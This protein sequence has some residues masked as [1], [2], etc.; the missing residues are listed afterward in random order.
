[1]SG[2]NTFTV[3]APPPPTPSY[4]DVVMSDRPG[5]YWRLGESTGS[6]AVDE[7]ANGNAGS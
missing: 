6:T 5:G 1:M 2:A 4:R 7:T 3:A